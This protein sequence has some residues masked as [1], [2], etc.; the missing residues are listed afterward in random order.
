ML[1]RTGYPSLLRTAGFVDVVAEDVTGEYRATL[2]GW[3]RETDRRAV[4]VLAAVGQVE[5]DER[6]ARRIAAR[7][8][9]D[10]GVLARRRYRARRP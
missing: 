8:A 4:D 9:I 6:R 7:A 1:T 10:D 3:I 5:F 2:E